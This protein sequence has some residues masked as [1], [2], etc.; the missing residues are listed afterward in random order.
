MVLETMCCRFGETSEVPI[1]KELL[2]SE[3]PEQLPII[4]PRGGEGGW[5]GSRLGPTQWVAL[6]Q[7]LPVSSALGEFKTRRRNWKGQQPT[8]MG[9][10]PSQLRNLLV[11]GSKQPN[12]RTR[13][14]TGRP[15]A[16]AAQ[17]TRSRPEQAPPY[18]CSSSLTSLILLRPSSFLNTPVC[19]ALRAHVPTTDSPSALCGC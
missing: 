2:L 11:P 12:L 13:C 3:P 18:L 15:E 1:S 16:R 5:V 7:I 4:W 9:S 19:P 8:D 10:A 14:P 6:G 17:V